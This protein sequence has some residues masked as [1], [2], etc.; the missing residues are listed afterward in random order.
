LSALGIKADRLQNI[1]EWLHYKTLDDLFAALGRGD[2]K[3][4]QVL[5]GLSPD[6]QPTV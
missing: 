1:A 4:S 6:P 5:A 3:V 2:L